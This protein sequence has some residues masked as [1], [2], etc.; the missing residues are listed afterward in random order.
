[1]LLGSKFYST[2]F[3]HIAGL[4]VTQVRKASFQL[5]RLGTS[6]L[7]LSQLKLIVSNINERLSKIILSM[8]ENMS[9]IKK[10]N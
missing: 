10:E 3:R 2:L 5:L 7:L 6:S 8:K 1:M 9:N 4:E